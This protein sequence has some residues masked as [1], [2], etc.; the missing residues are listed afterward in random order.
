M[1]QQIEEFE[2]ARLEL[3]E[4][5]KALN[6]AVSAK[7]QVIIDS[8]Q[9]PDAMIYDINSLLDEVPR[10]EHYHGTRRLYEAILRLDNGETLK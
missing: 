1:K 6:K 3:K 4:K 8:G 10:S 7:M 2:V 5:E 9:T